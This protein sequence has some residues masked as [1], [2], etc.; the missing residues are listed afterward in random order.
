MASLLIRNGADVNAPDGDGWTPLK[1]AAFQGDKRIAKTLIDAGADVSI[2]LAALVGHAERVRRSIASGVDVNARDDEGL[3]PLFLAT[4]GGHSGVVDM[5]MAHGADPNAR[6]GWDEWHPLYWHRPRAEHF[7]SSYRTGTPAEPGSGLT[8]L[9]HAAELGF[10]DVAEVLIARAAEIGVKDP[11]GRTPLNVAA[12]AGWGDVVETLLNLGADPNAKDHD[13]R[14]ALDHAR[15]AG[16]RD[17]CAVLG[18]GRDDPPPPLRGPRRVV[19]TDPNA[20]RA[21]LGW[22]GIA[23]D[24]VWI[25]AHDDL[26]GLDDILRAHLQANLAIG[27]RGGIP[28]EPVLSSLRRYHREYGGFMRNGR[29]HI[30]CNMFLMDPNNM[31]VSAR[32]ADSF[33]FIAD[34]YW[35]VVQAVFSLDTKSPV[36]IQCNGAA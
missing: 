7:D 18:D 14:T 4:R 29:R 33:T 16:F 32:S 2:H 9:H 36:E 35:C 30:L 12:Y 34:G 20:V 17:V 25:P 21:F 6:C 13:G 26:K 3:T 24:R 22:E 27:V 11:L 8:A 28:R 10:A 19:I 23:H 15:E 5:L 31:F 1:R